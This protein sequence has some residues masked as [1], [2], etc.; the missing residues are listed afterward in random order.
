MPTV[1][2]GLQV[3][4]VTLGGT[5]RQDMGGEGASHRHRAHR[6][7]LAAGSVVAMAMAGG[8]GDGHGGASGNRRG[9]EKVE[10]SCYRHQRVDRLGDGLSITARAADD[11]RSPRATGPPRLVHGGPVAPQGH[12]GLR[13]RA[14]GTVQRAG[15][16]G[17]GRAS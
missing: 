4:K 9:A 6:V 1:C 11:R 15:G 13:R 14:A 5:L 3:V 7:A 12:G 17:S 16:R 2:R 8:E 10:V